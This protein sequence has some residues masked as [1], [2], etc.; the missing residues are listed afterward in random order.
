MKKHTVISVVIILMLAVGGGY[1]LWQNQ[2]RATNSQD[3]PSSNGSS[4]EEISQ[5][6]TD[7]GRVKEDQVVDDSPDNNNSSDNES[8][9]PSNNDS[10]GNSEG[11][12]PEKPNVTR[13]EYKKSDD[14]VRVAAIFDNSSDGTC[15]LRLEKSGYNT[16]K[17][18]AGIITAPSYYACDGFRV[19]ANKLPARGEWKATVTHKV[20]ERTTVSDSHLIKVE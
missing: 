15:L 1:A 7:P 20:D 18:T 2:N 4:Q 17:R 11:P 8:S 14:E 12:A 9:E 13:A 19:A 6:E 3:K 10:S 5:E 16:V